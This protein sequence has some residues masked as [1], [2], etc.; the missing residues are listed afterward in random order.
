MAISLVIG[1]RAVANIRTS[2]L[3]DSSPS[4]HRR[5]TPV[6]STEGIIR[7]IDD[8]HLPI[9]QGTIAT[10]Y[11][12]FYILITIV[13]ALE[14]RRLK[15]DLFTLRGLFERNLRIT[16]S[17]VDKSKGFED[18]IESQTDQ[19]GTTAE[20]LLVWERQGILEENQEFEH[21]DVQRRLMQFSRRISDL[22]S[23]ILRIDA[24]LGRG[25]DP[26]NIT[27]L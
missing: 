12:L 14:I 10:I 6:I 13:L 22:R 17:L 9:A 24:E 26:D 15:Q 4:N 2:L 3:I 11:H 7:F 23:I 8:E 20:L 5:R 25:T 16:E 21:A 18:Y 27:T 19:P 1:I